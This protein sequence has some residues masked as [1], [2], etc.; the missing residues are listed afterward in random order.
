METLGAG[1]ASAKSMLGMAPARP[2]TLFEE[3]D[4]ATS[5]SWKNPWA[6]ACN[7][8]VLK[9]TL[10]PSSVAATEQRI[11]AFAV[12]LAFGIG[13]CFL[14]TWFLVIPRT[15]A[16]FYTVGSLF[17]IGSTFFLMGPWKQLQS[18]FQPARY[19]ST[20]IYFGA[21]GGTLYAALSLHN[22]GLTLIMVIVQFG[23]ALWYGASYVPF[24]QQFLMGTARTVLPL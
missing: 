22:T 11:V 9:Y 20:L 8:L 10:C 16:K 1:L 19:M 5:L 3:L 17:L 14:S 2:P 4:S 15:F 6:V 23:A 18:M 7:M 24:C 21:M 12:C 13:F